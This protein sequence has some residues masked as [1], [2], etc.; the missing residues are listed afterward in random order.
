AVLAAAKL[1]IAG[2]GQGVF[3][4]RGDASMPLADFDLVAE[5]REEPFNLPAAYPEPGPERREVTDAVAAAV[6]ALVKDRDTIQIGTGTLSALMGSY[7]THKRDLGVD[8]EILVASVI[9]LVK[10]GAATGRY[11]TYHPGVASG[12]FVVRGCDI[13]LFECSSR[14]AVFDI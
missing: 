4:A 1:S 3:R 13:A 6:A 5:S 10:C 14:G 8:C 7:L 2:V 12:S 9:E 11:K